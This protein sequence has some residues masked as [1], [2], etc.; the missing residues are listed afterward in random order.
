MYEVAWCMLSFSSVAKK[1][2]RWADS[3]P[4]RREREGGR[5]W[6]TGVIWMEKDRDRGRRDERVIGGKEWKRNGAIRKEKAGERM[7]E[8]AGNRASMGQS[9]RFQTLVT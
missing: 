4:L 7:I 6:G 5:E 9:N 2:W 1:S 8:E 3:T